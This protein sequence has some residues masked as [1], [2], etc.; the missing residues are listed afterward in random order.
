[1]SNLLFNT[2]K[3]NKVLLNNIKKIHIIRQNTFFNINI[4]FNNEILI[5][6]Y[7]KNNYGK[8]NF[9]KSPE[10]IIDKVSYLIPIYDI[11]EIENYDMLYED[12]K[13]LKKINTNILI[14]V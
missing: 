6:K 9:Y 13:I 11:N 12:I 3:N 4:I 10:Y 5:N 2:L 1:M 8:Y 7:I 14:E